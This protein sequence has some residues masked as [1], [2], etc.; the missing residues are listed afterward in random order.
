MLENRL[1]F[2]TVF[3]L[4]FASPALA[5]SCGPC[6]T[7]V[8]NVWSEENYAFSY[9]L[10]AEVLS[11]R[12]LPSEESFDSYG[13]EA[14][15]YQIVLRPIEISKGGQQKWLVV[16]S[17]G[18]CGLP[19]DVGEKLQIAAKLGAGGNL[20]VEKCLNHCAWKLG[21]FDSLTPLE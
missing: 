8:D 10:S 21:K 5:C 4:L 12:E 13:Y 2:F 17:A 9:I 19:V 3:C 1:A 20:F 11:K 15:A 6:T 14:D 16:R 7:P 18:S